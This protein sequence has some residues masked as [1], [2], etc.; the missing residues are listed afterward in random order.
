MWLNL[1]LTRGTTVS[2]EEEALAKG[3]CSWS[4]LK[5]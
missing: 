2:K 4:V 3:S 1:D 5:A